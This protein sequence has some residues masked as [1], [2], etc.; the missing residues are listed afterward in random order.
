MSQ[1]ILWWRHSVFC[2]H[3][4]RFDVD[5]IIRDLVTPGLN[6]LITLYKF[7]VNQ[8]S[9]LD[10]IKFKW[11]QSFCFWYVMYVAIIT[12]MHCKHAALHY[13][14]CEF[15]CNNEATYVNWLYT[16]KAVERTNSSC[17]TRL[18]SQI[19]AHD[20]DRVT[21]CLRQHDSTDIIFIELVF[22]FNILSIITIIWWF[23][24]IVSI[25]VF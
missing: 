5:A 1:Q 17:F 25:S 11:K 8:C 12:M 23:I 19:I 3:G 18:S 9:G 21:Y 2:Y 13:G 14:C 24:L 20:D 16:R 15:I 7:R 10:I 22:W 6:Y 4:N